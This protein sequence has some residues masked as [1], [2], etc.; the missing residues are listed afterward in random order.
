MAAPICLGLLN[1]SEYETVDSTGLFIT[2]S[3]HFLGNKY[4]NN[5]SIRSNELEGELRENLESLFPE[6]LCL[7][8]R[9]ANFFDRAFVSLI[10]GDD[11]RHPVVW[12]SFRFTVMQNFLQESLGRNLENYKRYIRSFPRCVPP[13]SEAP[14][15]LL[16]DLLIGFYPD[17]DYVPRESLGH[18][19]NKLNVLLSGSRLYYAFKFTKILIDHA[20]KE[21]AIGSIREFVLETQRSEDDRGYFV[22]F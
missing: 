19:S 15:A 21:G 20:D 1:R 16:A 22:Y 6:D 7:P 13:E 8:C 2:T 4:G 3:F 17:L 9:E 11:F 10:N 14:F 18:I 12:D 5:T